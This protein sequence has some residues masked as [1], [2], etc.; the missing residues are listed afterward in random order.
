MSVELKNTP[1]NQRK[2][3]SILRLILPV[4]MMG[5]LLAMGLPMP[6]KTMNLL[7]C[8]NIYITAMI[9]LLSTDTFSTVFSE[10]DSMRKY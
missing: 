10:N 8:S 6:A 3:F 7:I 9:M 5:I 1:A 4:V 2:N